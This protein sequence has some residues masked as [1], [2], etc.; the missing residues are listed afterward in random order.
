MKCQKYGIDVTGCSKQT[1]IQNNSICEICFSEP[2]PKQWISR[3]VQKGR[4]KAICS[5][6]GQD[7]FDNVNPEKIITCSYCVQGLL[8]LATPEK[9][10]LRERLIEKGDFEGSRSVQSFI[11]PGKEEETNGEGRL[12]PIIERKRII[13]S[14]RN[15]TS[16]AVRI[17]EKRLPLVKHRGKGV[18]F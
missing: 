18:L 12:R 16:Y 7:V 15:I 3:R 9:T 14:V 5:V 11:S 2:K 13:K 4:T 17:P 8:L 1:T 6:C 10:K